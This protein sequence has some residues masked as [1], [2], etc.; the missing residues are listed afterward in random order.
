MRLAEDARHSECPRLVSKCLT[1]TPSWPDTG[2]LPDRVSSRRV[3]IS[4]SAP[5][6]SFMSRLKRSTAVVLTLFLGQFFLVRSAYGCLDRLQSVADSSMP[7]A[8]Q[9]AAPSP[10]SAAPALRDVPTDHADCSEPNHGAGCAIGSTC[11]S[12]GA[13]GLSAISIGNGNSGRSPGLLHTVTTLSV[14]AL[15]SRNNPPEPPPPRA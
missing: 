10:D 15:P 4:G 5:T 1:Y 13:C 14:R 7:A 8:A 9:H 3:I 6:S 11:A 12:M 2:P